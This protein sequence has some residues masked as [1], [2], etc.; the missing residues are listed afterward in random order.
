M[1]LLTLAVASLAFAQEPTT[2]D[3]LANLDK[4]AKAFTSLEASIERAQVVAKFAHPAEQ[5]KI[6]IKMADGASRIFMEI[7]KPKELSKTLLL[8]KG[9]GTA[10]FPSTNTYME[11][12]FDPKNDEL[13]LLLIGFGTPTA[14][15]TK[16]YTAESRG[17]ETLNGVRTV[18]LELTSIGKVSGPYSKIVLWLD[19]ETWTPTQTR[20]V[21]TPNTYTDVKYSNVRLNRGVSDTVFRPNVPKDAK[22]Q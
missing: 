12:S 14:I 21:E 2:N 17:R 16:T 19:T 20:L 11:K 3:I 1:L 9:K 7:T 13:S 4:N 22:R 6:Y 8:D 10:Y 15:L 5:G 18:V